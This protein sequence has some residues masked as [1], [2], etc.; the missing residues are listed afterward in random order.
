M[1]YRRQ[2][3]IQITHR[4]GF[5]KHVFKTH[6]GGSCTRQWS[7]NSSLL[8]SRA[9]PPCSP[10]PYKNSINA[11]R[12]VAKNSRLYLWWWC[13]MGFWFHVRVMTMGVVPSWPERVAHTIQ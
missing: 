8:A 12:P 7:H 11:L 2:C 10:S 13:F 1:L 3:C 6:V 5:F 4:L 9:C